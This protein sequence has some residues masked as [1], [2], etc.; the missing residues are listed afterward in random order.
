MPHWGSSVSDKTL[1]REEQSIRTLFLRLV[2]RLHQLNTGLC[3]G[4]LSV[5]FCTQITIVILRYLF[6]IGFIELQDLVT[7]CFA[8]FCVLAIP[9]AFR[10][11]GHVRVDIFREM[12]SGVAVRRVDLFAIFVFLLP[13]FTITLWYSLPLVG[14]SWSILEGSRETGG[15]PGFFVVTTALPISCMLIILQGLALWL[16]P[17]Q[18]QDWS[19]Q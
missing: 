18:M 9:I 10:N 16:T 11:D 7:Y 12:Q 14:Y 2:G 15:L 5:I 4:L 6:K 1:D 8:A 3:L 19:K 17:N 13:V